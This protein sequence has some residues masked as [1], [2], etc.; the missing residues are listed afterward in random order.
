MLALLWWVCCCHP[1]SAGGGFMDEGFE[2]TAE[3]AVPA[4]LIIIGGELIAAGL[5]IP[6]IALAEGL[7]TSGK[8]VIGLVVAFSGLPFLFAAYYWKSHIQP[9][10]GPQ[11]SHSIESVAFDFR[12]WIGLVFAVTIGCWLF[13]FFLTQSDHKLIR[14]QGAQVASLRADFNC[15]LKPRRLKAEQISKIASYLSAHEPHEITVKVI[16]ND[17]EASQFSSDI[18]QALRQGGWTVV[19]SQLDSN[20][21]L[22]ISVLNAGQAQ[23]PM[24]CLIPGS[25][26]LCTQVLANGNTEPTPV[27]LICSRV[28]VK[29]A[30]PEGGTTPCAQWPCF[31]AKGIGNS[32][33]TWQQASSPMQVQE[34]LSTN[35][36]QT[37]EHSQ[38]QLDPKH[39]NSLALLTEAFNL[40]N[41]QLDGG[42]SGGGGGITKD[43]L[44]IVIGRRRRDGY[45]TGCP[46]TIIKEETVPAP[47]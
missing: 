40:A 19:G 35:F 15:Y 13:A 5:C 4:V 31:V 17:S 37:Q 20:P 39:P 32:N 6:A 41:V 16:S 24:Y 34:G 11:F 46:Q 47:E 21:C 29:G 9:W 45:G 10:I 8:T 7:L 33:F 36:M 44:S 38:T 23:I 1:Y 42:S 22:G 26:V 3:K 27:P 18:G 12:Y 25:G 30:M 28:A 43:S 2:F 14:S